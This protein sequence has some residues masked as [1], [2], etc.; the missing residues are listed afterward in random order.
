MLHG[1]YLLAAA[2]AFLTMFPILNYV[3]F[4]APYS[5]LPFLAREDLIVVY[6]C[7]TTYVLILQYNIQNQTCVT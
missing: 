3:V 4:K 2:K 7:L 6:T 1:K 5:T